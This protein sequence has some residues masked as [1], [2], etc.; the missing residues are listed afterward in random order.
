MTERMKRNPRAI[1]VII[2]HKA[3]LSAWELI[4]LRQC[5][6][7][8]GAHPITLLLPA[9]L[10]TSWY[11]ACVPE[12]RIEFVDRRWLASY[13]MFAAFK[14]SPILYERYSDFEYILFYE[15]DAFAFSDQLGFW[16]DQG[17]D[18][19]GAPWFEGFGNPSG[20]RIIGVGNGGFSLRKVESHL[21]IA[22]RFQ[23]EQF[24]FHGYREHSLDKIRF[25][26][27]ALL[28]LLGF[29]RPRPYY[30]GP[31][32]YGHEDIFWGR[33]VPKR[34]PHFR[35]ATPEQAIP[36]SFET[37]PRQ[38]FKMNGERLP[39]GCHAWFRYDLEFWRPHIEAFG[40]DL[41]LDMDS[42]PAPS[43]HASARN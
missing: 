14:I 6:N 28:S 7:V 13:A 29:E 36:F 20:D 15:P 31:D 35:V 1:V 43:G 40:H 10:D 39:F 34:Y 21:Q 16:C 41:G 38:L 18:Y 37:S 5:V 42:I 8:L 9:G 3:N 22:R 17:L 27:A 24:L 23:S 26:K 4:S 2:S 32:H 33:S 30:L 12:I 25:A 19:I 11:S